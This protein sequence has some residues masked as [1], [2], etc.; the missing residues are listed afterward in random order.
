MSQ[1]FA[2]AIIALDLASAKKVLG[3]RS[4][5]IDD[6]FVA[7]IKHASDDYQ[8]NRN[9]SAA[10]ETLEKL[11]WAG[12]KSGDGYIES[13]A[14]LSA[15]YQY[16]EQLI[17]LAE[18]SIGAANNQPKNS[19][20]QQIANEAQTLLNAL[21]APPVV[22][23]NEAEQRDQLEAELL[24]LEADKQ[25]ANG[26]LEKVEQQRRAKLK[27]IE[28]DKQTANH[29]LQNVEQQ[30]QY[31]QAQVTAL[32]NIAAGAPLWVAIV[33]TEMQEG[34]LSSLT[35]PLLEKLRFIVPEDAEPLRR[36]IYARQ[37]LMPDAL[38]DPDT[39]VG[40][41]RLFAGI[42]NAAALESSDFTRATEVLI[43][44]WENYLNNLSGFNP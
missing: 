33:Q 23:L 19:R 11:Y 44:A 35:L 15:A 37:G 6:D 38:L 2:E 32:L 31:A 43:D 27:Q 14:L 3:E 8:T 22:G 26:E 29:E 40:D 30:R 36:E 7:Y 12:K 20:C 25:R 1:Q 9:P 17:I 39:L 16:K 42:L 5:E 21:T 13:Y 24:K 4:K 34:Q 41:Q 10:R 18:G 28:A